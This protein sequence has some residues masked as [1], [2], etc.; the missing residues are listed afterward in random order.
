MN[1]QDLS[2]KLIALTEKYNKLDSQY[3][4]IEEEIEFLEFQRDDLIDEMEKLEEKINEIK[5]QLLNAKLKDINILTG[6][7]FTDLFILAS[8]F[9][10]KDEDVRP[11]FQCVHL[12]DSELIALDGK[13]GIVIKCD[14][15]PEELQNTAIKW[16][17][18]SNFQENIQNVEKLPNLKKVI[19]DGVTQAKHILSDIFPKD[20]YES[21]KMSTH[22][23]NEECH[24]VRL[25]YSDTFIAVNKEYI[26]NVLM[27]FCFSNEKFNVH[28]KDRVSPIIFENDNISAVVLP[29]R[30]SQYD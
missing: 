30:I 29:V 10:G 15:I 26:D 17:A 19:H 5:K 3:R 7:K 21:F 25:Y 2:T 20:F 13:R 6:D 11:S 12:N 4:E 28:I 24:I 18:R 8:Y 9:T 23:K 1:R 22:L 27:C 14:C 16:D